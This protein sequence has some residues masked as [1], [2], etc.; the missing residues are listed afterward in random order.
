MLII[1]SILGAVCANFSIQSESTGVPSAVYIV[2]M[3]MMG[4]GAC[5]S[6]FLMPPS[7]VVRDDGT[8]VTVVKSRGILEELKANLEIFRDW[9]LMIMVSFSGLIAQDINF[10]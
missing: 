5:A 6:F 3:V 4:C 10:Y 9:K 8:P 1:Q 2:F 7:R